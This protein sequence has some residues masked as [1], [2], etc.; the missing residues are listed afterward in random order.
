MV[1]SITI[2]LWNRATQEAG[3]DIER[4]LAHADRH[5][6]G[7]Y[8]AVGIALKGELAVLRGAHESG[9]TLLRQA[10]ASLK[11]EQHHVLTTSFSRALAEGLILCGDVDLATSTIDDALAHVR[12]RGETLYLC[13][14]LRVRADA[15][16]ATCPHCVGAAEVL[17]ECIAEARQ[18]G[19]LG[20]EL[21]AMLSLVPV[22]RRSG[23]GEEALEML[24]GLVERFSEGYT[25][26]DLRAAQALLDQEAGSPG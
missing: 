13:D 9:V 15:L 25:T 21:R 16:L 2:Q 18:S 4:L 7:P 6:L 17:L 22:W 8:H 5:S 23:R 26:G 11:T 3:L 14:L 20:F 19:A 1:Y 12:L 24:A 10:L